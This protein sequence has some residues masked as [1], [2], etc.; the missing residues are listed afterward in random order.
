LKRQLQHSG[1]AQISTVDPESRSLVIK[2]DIVE[3]AYNT[4]VATDKKNALIVHYEVTNK[5]DRKALHQ[6]CLAAKENM[7]LTKEAPLIA[8]ADKGYFNGEQLDAC[9]KDHIRTYVPVQGSRPAGPI[10]ARGYYGEDFHYDKKTDSYLCPEGHR[11]TTNGQWYL[12]GRDLKGDKYCFLVKHYKTNQCL[13]CPAFHLCTN[14]KKGRLIERS[15]YAEAVEQN[16]KRLKL[17]KEIYLKRQQ[18]VEH[19]FG[20]IKLGGGATPIPY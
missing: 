13:Q 1:E 2:T 9:Y 4:Q 14:N 16:H 3:V 18:I 7:G 10:P 11:L 12:R 15:Q 20:T 6:S 19:P 5:L 8:L 17:H